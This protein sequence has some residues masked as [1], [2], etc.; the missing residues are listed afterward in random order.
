MKILEIFGYSL[1]F[2]FVIGWIDMGQGKDL[3]YWKLIQ[4]IEQ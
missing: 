1:A 3:T 4:L 2:L